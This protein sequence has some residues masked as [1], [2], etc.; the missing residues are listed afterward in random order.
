[1]ITR[2]AK[3]IVTME[4]A[5]SSNLANSEVE[6]MCKEARD[7]AI[8]ETEAKYK[9]KVQETF[10]CVVCLHVPRDGHITQCQ[11]GHLICAVCANKNN[12]NQCP[13]CRAEMDQ[14]KGNKRIRTLVAEQLIESMDLSF[15][16]KHPPCQVSASKKEIIIH[17]K[18]CTNRMVPCPDICNKE[19]VYHGLLKHLKDSGC[20]VIISQSHSGYTCKLT[21][22]N[23]DFQF[24]NLRWPCNVLIV[25]LQTYLITTR[26]IDGIFYSYV[27]IMGDEEEARKFKVAL[28]IGKG[29]QS[30]LVH[31]GQVFP[32]DAKGRT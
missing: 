25:N 7:K 24:K 17:E 6:R 10:Q 31:I 32:I 9:R 12:N 11:N 2:Q 14:L 18:K 8:K 27:Q 4:P 19:I 16:C 26:K 13:S 28:S 20:V 1:M 22:Q 23:T 30:G 29:G 3:K 21:Q 15:P 5:K